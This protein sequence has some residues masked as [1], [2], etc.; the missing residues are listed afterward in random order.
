MVL[1]APASAALGPAARR[2]SPHPA[3]ACAGLAAMTARPTVAWPRRDNEPWQRWPV[4]DAGRASTA[5]RM[6]RDRPEG[7]GD[8]TRAILRHRS[9]VLPVFARCLCVSPLLEQ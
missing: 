3:S 9:W 2:A 7:H 5:R 6:G 8:G 1:R 4:M